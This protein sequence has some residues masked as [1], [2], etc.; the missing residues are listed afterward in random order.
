MPTTR[1]PGSLLKGYC[2]SGQNSDTQPLGSRVLSGGN[3]EP[4]DLGNTVLC[5]VSH[6]C[7]LRQTPQHEDQLQVLLLKVLTARNTRAPHIKAELSSGLQT[8][9]H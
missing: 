4:W 2:G 1:N 3:P 8:S 5:S 9:Q 6:N 7:V